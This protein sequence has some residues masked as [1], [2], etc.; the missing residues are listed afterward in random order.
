[1]NDELEEC[2]VFPTTRELLRIARGFSCLF[3]GLPLTVL[4]FFR[5][6]DVAFLNQV[7]MPAYLLGVAVLYF[8]MGLHYFCGLESP[9]WRRTARGGLF[10]SFL[11]LYFGPFVY[12]FSSMPRVGVYFVVNLILLMISV[13]WLLWS[14][15]W[16][17][18][19]LGTLTGD[20]E[21]AIEARVCAWSV[22][23]LMLI[24]SV[25][26]VGVSSIMAARYE[27]SLVSEM[28]GVRL[29]APVWVQIFYLLPLSLTMVAVWKAKERSLQALHIARGDEPD[30]FL[31]E[32]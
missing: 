5:A 23:V 30:P 4:L 32:A 7:R 8:G 1:M 26:V 22:V 27:S 15:S 16:L 10:S 2:P 13:M 3:W 31:T 20:A 21:L 24:P 11:L 17:S 6:I 28:Q 12:W 18:S 29:V 14:A 25:V 9:W 19:K